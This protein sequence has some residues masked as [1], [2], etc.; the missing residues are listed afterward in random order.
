MY[1][2]LGLKH[3]EILYIVYNLQCDSIDQWDSI[4]L[5]SMCQVFFSFNF[6]LLYNCKTL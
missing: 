2:H 1:Y 5:D 6:T 3:Y 4:Y